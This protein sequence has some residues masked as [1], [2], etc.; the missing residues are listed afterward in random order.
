MS[1]TTIG[2]LGLLLMGAA[3]A[4]GGADQFAWNYFL[5][6]IGGLTAVHFAVA[7][8]PKVARCD[9]LAWIAGAS[10]LGLAAFQLVPL[11]AEVTAILSPARYEIAR[12]AERLVGPYTILP[13]SSVPNKTILLLLELAGH[14][15]VILL[16]R[17]AVLRIREQCWVAALPIVL[18]CTAEAA[19][20][21]MQAAAGQAAR[22]GVG[23]FDSYDHFAGLVEMGVPF[24]A[25]FPFAIL[26][27]RGRG[28]SIGGLPAVLAGLSGIL[29]VVMLGGIVVAQSR[30]GYLATIA[31][32]FVGLVLALFAGSDSEDGEKPVWKF[33]AGGAAI[34]IG[35]AVLFFFLQSDDLRARFAESGDL[36]KEGRFQIW[37][38]T[39]RLIGDYPVFGCGL[40]AFESCYQRY[41]TS[42]I[43]NVVDYAHNDYLQVMAELGLLGFVVGVVF[44]GRIVQR[45]I[46]GVFRARLAQERYLMAAAVG[47]MSA[48]LVH[49]L[50]DFNMYLAG[51][52]MAF[53]WIAGIAAMQASKP[54]QRR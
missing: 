4:N 9:R 30:G 26:G 17:D 52:A 20:A 11:P 37:Q 21:I 36:Q 53:A 19:F 28:E 5:A 29:A 54:R 8:E 44:V 12:A 22:D 43:F 23:T 50:V 14:A 10:F 7:R 41:Q 25:V 24:A 39:S 16:M 38:D 27:Q 45:A 31:G 3:I 47:A 1:Y 46:R 35:I 48:M 6:A 2:V 40:G 33:V 34:A 32:L 18:I 49:S 51:N 13:I 15:A 42:A